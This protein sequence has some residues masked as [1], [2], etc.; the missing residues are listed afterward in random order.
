MTFATASQVDSSEAKQDEISNAARESLNRLLNSMSVID[1]VN[2]VQTILLS[3]DTK[4][5]HYYSIKA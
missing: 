4:V 3:G 5:V 1:F 2:S